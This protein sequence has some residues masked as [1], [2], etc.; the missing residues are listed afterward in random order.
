MEDLSKLAENKA[1]K[2]ADKQVREIADM[3][4]TKMN[5]FGWDW[6][7]GEVFVNLMLPDIVKQQIN[8]IKLGVK[9]EK[10]LKEASQKIN[11]QID[12]NDN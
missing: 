4:F 9:V 8:N 7:Q 10:T 6:Y 3:V 2:D 11:E 5:E 12:K 1:G